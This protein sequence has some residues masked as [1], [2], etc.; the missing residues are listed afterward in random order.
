MSYHS[1]SM[2][3]ITDCEFQK[4]KENHPK[5]TGSQL[6]CTVGSKQMVSDWANFPW[7]ITGLHALRYTYLFQ[8]W[9]VKKNNQC[10]ST[11]F[12]DST[13]KV[14][15]FQWFLCIGIKICIEVWI[16]F[17]STF[18]LITEYNMRVFSRIVY[19]FFKM[20]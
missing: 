8:T 20:Q 13:N 12:P 10:C 1:V 18:L 15:P 5:L 19:S 11:C 9:K 14:R 4:N 17:Q 7:P 16:F 6:Y 3:M 2:N